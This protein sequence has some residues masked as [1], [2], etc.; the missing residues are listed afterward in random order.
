[1]KKYLKYLSVYITKC[2]DP[3][4]FSPFLKGDNKLAS[5][6]LAVSEKLGTVAWQ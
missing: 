2:L 3:K 4:L 1:M 6:C 5:V